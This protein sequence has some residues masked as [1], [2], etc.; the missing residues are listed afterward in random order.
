M[1][2]GRGSSAGWLRGSPGDLDPGDRR[3][4]AAGLFHRRTAPWAADGLTLLLVAM[5][6]A[7]VHAALYRLLVNI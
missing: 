4:A 5:F 1:G 3:T 6:P 7:N 2:F